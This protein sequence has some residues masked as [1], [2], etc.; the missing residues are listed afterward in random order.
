[1]PGIET[2]DPDLTDTNN[3]FEE[4]PNFFSEIF[5]INLIS[6]FDSR[7]IFLEFFSYF[8]KIFTSFS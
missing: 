1:M 6:F 5:S 3:G 7:I 2:L 8:Y 4:S